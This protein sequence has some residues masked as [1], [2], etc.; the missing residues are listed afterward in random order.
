GKAEV[1]QN[2][3][4]SLAQAV[5]DELRIGSTSIQ[6][7]MGDTALT[8]FDLGTFG[9]RTTPTMAPRLRM[10]AATAREQMIAT[11][12]E[13][14]NVRPDALL[15]RDGFIYA[16]DSPRKISFGQIAGSIDWVKVLGRD[17]C[18]TPASERR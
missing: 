9:S 15:A 3:R 7:V 10:M 18:L 16:K 14:W 8:P 5:G 6:L 13:R 17:D 4:T 12:A 2:I 11:A 1:G